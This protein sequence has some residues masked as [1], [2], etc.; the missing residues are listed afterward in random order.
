MWIV[1]AIFVAGAIAL[2]VYLVFGRSSSSS[3]VAP[4][5]D[6]APPPD[7]TGHPVID[8]IPCETTERVTYH[9]H[10]HLAIYVNGNAA[11]VPY[12]IGIAPPRQTQNSDEGPFVTAGS[13]FYWLHAHTGDGIIHIE[14]PNPMPFT[15]GQYFDM[16]QQPL[17]ANQVGPAQGQVYAYLG[18]QPYNGDPRAIPIGDHTLVQLDVGLNQPAPQPFTFPSGL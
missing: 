14:A 13:C 5:T 17:S 8:N 10:T 3:A 2:I 7:Y 9:V 18:G 16:W 12:G 1:F 6:L 15:L 4:K 11:G